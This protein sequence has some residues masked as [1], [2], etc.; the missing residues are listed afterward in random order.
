MNFSEALEK[1][2]QGK[3]IRSK[4]WMLEAFISAQYPDEHSKMTRPYLYA[5]SKY[6]RVPWIPTHEDLF[7]ED[8]VFIENNYFNL[9]IE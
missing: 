8:W 4:E 5:T 2:K 3:K 1:A 7:S 6:G 9:I